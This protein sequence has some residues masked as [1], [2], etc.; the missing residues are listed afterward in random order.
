METSL[1]G[2]NDLSQTKRSKSPPSTQDVQNV[3][4]RQ[5][6]KDTRE[7]RGSPSLSEKTT[8]IGAETVRESKGES[9]GMDD[10]K[11]G[12]TE[13]LNTSSETDMEASSTQ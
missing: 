1:S 2:E 3:T 12:E 13:T 9:S 5:S 11:V 7:D 6:I 8:D 4:S 10:M